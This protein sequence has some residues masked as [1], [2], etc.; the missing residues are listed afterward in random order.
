MF[1]KKILLAILLF[2]VTDTI[3]AQGNTDSTKIVINRKVG[4]YKT[5]ADFLKNMPLV[6]KPIH[7]VHVKSSHKPENQKLTYEFI[8]S[9]AIIK[10]AWGVYDGDKVYINDGDDKY[11][12]MSIVGRY[13]FYIYKDYTKLRATSPTYLIMRTGGVDNARNM[14]DSTIQ[15]YN[16][17]GKLKKANNQSIGWLIRNEKDF[18]AEYNKEAY[19]DNNTFRKY[20]MKMNMR[21]PLD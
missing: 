13:S 12:P 18:V 17:K 10:D 8:D 2:S 15:F 20:L 9:S 3:N 7:I 19:L 5:Y 16:E 4:V 11:I 21:Y 1:I 6:V 14:F